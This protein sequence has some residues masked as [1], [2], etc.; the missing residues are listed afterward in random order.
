MCAQPDVTPQRLGVF[1]CFTFRG[2]IGSSSCNSSEKYR[3]KFGTTIQIFAVR[4]S[5]DKNHRTCG[6][7]FYIYQYV[8]FPRDCCKQHY[9]GQRA[10][11]IRPAKIWDTQKHS[12][13]KLQAAPNVK[14][15]QGRYVQLELGFSLMLSAF[16]KAMRYLPFMT[17][18]SPHALRQ[19]AARGKCRAALTLSQ[20]NLVS[21]GC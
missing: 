11:L 13:I 5:T 21:Q 16:L 8:V 17:P 9:V 4:L 19:H 14:I 7:I 18:L 3:T 1:D 15:F 2:S 20:M 10:N 6:V 12:E